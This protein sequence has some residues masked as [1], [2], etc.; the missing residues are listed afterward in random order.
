MI[1][2]RI[3][4]NEALNYQLLPP[5]DTCW[6][7]FITSTKNREANLKCNSN[8][9][10]WRDRH[11]T[12]LY[13]HIKDRGHYTWLHEGCGWETPTSYPEPGHGY[14]NYFYNLFP[15]SREEEFSRC[16]RASLVLEAML[17]LLLFP[18]DN[19]ARGRCVCKKGEF[20]FSIKAGR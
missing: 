11:Q 12:E 2:L 5:S 9:F 13:S 7:A 14:S 10:F 4:V 18:V 1:R 6:A 8:W 17:L 20:F 15:I 16:V 3:A 19:A